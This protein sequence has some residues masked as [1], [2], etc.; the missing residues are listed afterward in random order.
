MITHLALFA[1]LALQA[2]QPCNVASVRERARRDAGALTGRYVSGEQVLSLASCGARSEAR[3]SIDSVAVSPAEWGSIEFALRASADSFAVADRPH[4]TIVLLRNPEGRVISV[5]TTG[6]GIAPQ[7]IRAPSRAPLLVE[8]L[9]FERDADDIASAIRNQ[10]GEPAARRLALTE[11]IF[12]RFP[13]RRAT[14]LDAVH[15][16]ARRAP[17][18]TTLAR[19]R[20]EFTFIARRGSASHASSPMPSSAWNVPFTPNALLVPPS[21]AELDS[22]ARHVAR[23]SRKPDDVRELAR[24]SLVV[25]PDTFTVRIISDREHSDDGQAF[26]HIGAIIVPLHPGAKC[27]G[28]IVDVKGTNPSYSPLTLEPG[29]SSLRLLGSAASSYVFVV[30]SIRG[31]LLEAFGKEYHSEGNRVDGWDGGAEDALALLEAAATVVPQIDLSRVCTYGRSRG[32]TVALLAAERDGRI[33]CVV[34]IS[35]PMDWFDAMW[36]GGGD[37]NIALDRALR[38]HAMPSDLNGQFVERIVAPVS[39][40]EWT[41]ADARREMILSS[42][43]YGVKRL[44]PTLAIYGAEDTSVPVANAALFSAV[45]GRKSVLIMPMAGHDADPVEIVRRMPAFLAKYLGTPV[46]V[47]R[48]G[49][50][51]R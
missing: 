13:S 26:T 30:P 51:A 23:R 11:R 35:A 33:K 1:T 50:D 45:L 21:R 2:T 48:P 8:R 38:S 9:L 24:E 31:E 22:A 12:S 47:R 10:N 49:A 28:T 41:F 43:L 15:T 34:A 17:S 5:R 18:D 39:R 42:P 20:D 32:G 6:F 16:F 40:G 27:C 37:K 4:R 36:S 14:L 25:G 44:P 46:G 3:E 7:F 19:M 29:P